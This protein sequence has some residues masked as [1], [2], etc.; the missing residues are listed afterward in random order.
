[1]VVAGSV[2][3]LI[4]SKNWKARI[5]DFMSAASGNASTR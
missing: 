3:F 1:M 2:N 4:R 5:F